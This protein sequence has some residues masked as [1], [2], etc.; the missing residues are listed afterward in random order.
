MAK[1]KRMGKSRRAITVA[2]TLVIVCLI[3]SALWYMK[4]ATAG[5]HHPVFVYLP[6]V[7][8]VALAY[9]RFPALLG[10]CAATACAAYFLYDPLYSFTIANGLEIGDLVW[11]AL[12]AFIVVRCTD[13]LTRPPAQT[14]AIKSRYRLS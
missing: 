13:A 1:G 3:T 5:L 8:L 7:A 6:L 2:G 4:L 11:F 12:L 10:A 14:P 9:G